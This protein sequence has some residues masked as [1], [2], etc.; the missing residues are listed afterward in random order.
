MEIENE[1]L[2]AE[3]LLI[4][5][6]SLENQVNPHFL[7]NSLN[8][9][10][11]LIG[12]E[13]E[14]AHQYL[15]QLAV[16]YRYIMRQ[17][18]HVTLREELEFAQSYIDMMGIRYGD[19]LKGVQ[20]IAPQCLDKLVVPISLQLLIEN[21]IKHNVISNHHPL[22]IHLATSGDNALVVSNSLQ[23]KNDQV[24]SEGIGLD[25]LNQRYMLLFEREITIRQTASEFAVEIPLIAE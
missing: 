11:G 21:A 14:K 15:H 6:Q 13:D 7:F 20:Q 8:T 12:L 5:Y 23:P 10:D 25:N 22:T 17:A 4:R 19:N 1:H 2:R 16:S 24:Q 18:K 3:N 9:L